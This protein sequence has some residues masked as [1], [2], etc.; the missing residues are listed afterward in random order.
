MNYRDRATKL[1]V[2][3][4]SAMLRLSTQHSCK[5]AKKHAKPVKSGQKLKN[6]KTVLF[7]SSEIKFVHQ[8]FCKVLICHISD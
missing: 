4:L 3:G 8:E 6:W 2:N 1:T 7:W 5:L